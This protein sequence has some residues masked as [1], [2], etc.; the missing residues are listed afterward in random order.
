MLF[1]HI[2]QEERRTR[3][4]NVKMSKVTFLSKGVSALFNLVVAVHVLGM[5]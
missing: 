3:G 5:L 4:I 2:D 1:I